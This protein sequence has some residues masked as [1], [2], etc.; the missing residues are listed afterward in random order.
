[1]EAK[2]YHGK[3][4]RMF[5]STCNWIQV[6][7]CMYGR[8]N[9]QSDGWIDGR[10][11]GQTEGQTREQSLGAFSSGEQKLESQSKTKSRTNYAEHHANMSE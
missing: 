1:M 10:I 3:Q 5:P 9:M 2:A 4:T 6:S 7:I 11:E 8:T